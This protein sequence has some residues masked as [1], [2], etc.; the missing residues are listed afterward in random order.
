MDSTSSMYLNHSN[1]QRTQSYT[2]WSI[3]CTPIDSRDTLFCALI[4]RK[5]EDIC[6]IPV[7]KAPTPTEKSKKQRDDIKNATK[8]FDYTTIAD[9]LRTVS[10]VTAVT[11]LV[12]FTGLR[13]HNLP[14]NR[15]RRVIKRKHI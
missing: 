4:L 9:R 7:T 12:W 15:N 2:G 8:N 14:T 11:Q 1:N 10:R 5:K 6:L 3:F 13:A